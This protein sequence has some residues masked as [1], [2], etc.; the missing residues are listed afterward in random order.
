MA[1]QRDYDLKKIKKRCLIL[2][3]MFLSGFSINTYSNSPWEAFLQSSDKDG[4][5]ILM[6]SIAASAQ[7]CSWGNPTN[8]NVTPTE[9][10]NKQLLELISK[11]NEPT[12]FAVLLVSRCLDGGDLEDFYRSAG[13]FF[14]AKPRVFLQIVKGR[15]ISDSQIKYLL[16][17][18]PLDTDDI[19]RKVNIVD[20][21]IALLRRID[22]GTLEEIKK[23]GLSFLEKEKKI[24]AE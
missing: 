20:N 17:M 11:G 2:T 9:R 1:V 10:Q 4:L 8:Q 16:T 6:N 24:S 3:L 12:F 18:L 21:R 23:R 15:G 5:A 22:E 13:N 14:E 7:R 19:D